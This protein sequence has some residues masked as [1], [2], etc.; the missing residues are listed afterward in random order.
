M[1]CGASTP[2]RGVPVESMYHPTFDM[3]QHE[4]HMA[5]VEEGAPCKEPSPMAKTVRSA[6]RRISSR[7]KLGLS[8]TEFN[9]ELERRPQSPSLTRD[10]EEWLEEGAENGDDAPPPVCKEPPKD[11]LKAAEEEQAT[12]K[13]AFDAEEISRNAAA[14][15]EMPAIALTHRLLSRHN[16]LT[17]LHSNAGSRFSLRSRVSSEMTPT[18]RNVSF[19]RTEGTPPAA[20]RLL[21][22]YSKAT[23]TSSMSPNR[24]P[25]LLPHHLSPRGAGEKPVSPLTPFPHSDDPQGGPACP[26]P[27][28]IPRRSSGD[29]GALRAR[30][31]AARLASRGSI[32]SGG[33]SSI[34]TA[35]SRHATPEPEPLTD[36][37]PQDI[38][39]TVA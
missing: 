28:P 3:K 34:P 11:C 27:L 4:L 30:F 36:A 15:Q 29:A 12:I 22:P 14:E 20:P 38:T 17:P 21:F 19:D 23:S 13:A 39:P 1:G 18:T 7:A 33:L 9:P 31:A 16:T 24:V 26:C 32:G 10:I 25:P 37:D 2:G 8:G 5:L 35:E 6:L